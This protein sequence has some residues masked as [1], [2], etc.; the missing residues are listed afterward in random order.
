MNNQT[1]V[2]ISWLIGLLLP[3]IGSVQAFSV[4]PTGGWIEI[5]GQFCTDGGGQPAPCETSTSEAPYQTYDRS[6]D[7][8]MNAGASVDANY[9]KAD[10][11]GTQ[12]GGRVTASFVDI[13]TL[14]GPEG[15]PLS[16]S[17]SLHVTGSRS[18]LANSAIGFGLLNLGGPGA[19]ST[20]SGG[21][22]IHYF[23]SSHPVDVNETLT[24]P[25]PNIH[26]GSTFSFATI[27]DLLVNTGQKAEF[28]STAVLG[29]TLPEGYFVS[30]QFNFSGEGSLTPSNVPLPMSLGFLGVGVAALGIVRQRANSAN[31]QLSR[32]TK[33]NP[34]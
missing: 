27:V 21:S 28:G 9:V 20:F 31:R 8:V 7:A 34:V 22:L 18:S 1:F 19:R 13:Y 24:L 25:L 12:L 29:F 2:Y 6:D 32:S 16:F 26:V 4:P 3:S 17:A 33:G 23:N 11:D 14:H 15:A 10:I 5:H 30:S